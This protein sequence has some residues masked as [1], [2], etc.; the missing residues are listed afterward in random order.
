MNPTL[1]LFPTCL[2]QERDYVVWGLELVLFA[3]KTEEDGKNERCG[4]TTG[5]ITH[6]GCKV[7]SSIF[8]WGYKEEAGADECEEC[9]RKRHEPVRFVYRNE[10]CGAGP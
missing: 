9:C 5:D 10:I 2:S 4:N 7:Q 8:C 1:V 3:G 6:L